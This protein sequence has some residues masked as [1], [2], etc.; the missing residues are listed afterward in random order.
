MDKTVLHTIKRTLVFI[1]IYS[2]V[3]FILSCKKE[4]KEKKII[5]Q[6]E[7]TIVKTEKDSISDFPKTGKQIADF[8]I[9]PYEIQYRAEGLLDDDE[10]ADAVIVLQ[11]KSDKSTSRPT[12]VLLKQPNGGYK[13]QEISWVAIAPD[14]TSDDYKI[15]DTESI[16]ISNKE[17]LFLLYGI[18]PSGNK[19]TIYKFEQN[20]LILINVNTYNA[21]AGGQSTMDYNLLTGDINQEEVNTM[22][23]S[24]PTTTTKKILKLKRKIYFD[25]DDPE[26]VL[27]TIFKIIL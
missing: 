24:M 11:N 8:V 19:E 12:L 23:D 5:D 10:F 7:K 3:F 16:S 27:D 21:G 15:Y 9:S 13:L 26:K 17:L 18:G 14:Y 4:V 25:K 6:E 22:I 1:G 2:S 20:K